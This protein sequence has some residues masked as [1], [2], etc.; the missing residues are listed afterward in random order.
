MTAGLA[1]GYGSKEEWQYALA[2]FQEYPSWQQLISTKIGSIYNLD[3]VISTYQQ[4]SADKKWL[5]LY[6]IGLK[7]F[8]AGKDS[9]LNKAVETASSP[10]ELVHNLYRTIL[11]IESTDSIF[12]S[13]YERRKAHLPSFS[14]K[15]ISYES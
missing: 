12:A 7:L 10:A 8:H 3:I 1:E 2:E 9:Y 6:F 11:E 4:N 14:L 5:W 15:E 13:I